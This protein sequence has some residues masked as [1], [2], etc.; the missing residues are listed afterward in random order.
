MD[1]SL[2]K[3]GERRADDLNVGRAF[4][5]WARVRI[6]TADGRDAPWRHASARAAF[7]HE[8]DLTA[9]VDRYLTAAPSLSF[10]ETL[11]GGVV[12]P[13]GATCEQPNPCLAAPT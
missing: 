9:I 3:S 10:I 5:S 12:G 2:V 1:V 4:L 13:A 6:Q 11:G 8:E 7:S